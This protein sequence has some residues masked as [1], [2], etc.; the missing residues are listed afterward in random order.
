MY[1][2]GDDTVF[3]YQV[4]GGLEIA[5]NRHFSLDLGYR[6][7]GTETASINSDSLFVNSLDYE[8]HNGSVGFRLKF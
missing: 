1:D 2:E 5:L 4:G 7:F 8:S 6:Y 3:A